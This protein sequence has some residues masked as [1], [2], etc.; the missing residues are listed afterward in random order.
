[1]TRMSRGILVLFVDKSQASLSGNVFQY[2]QDESTDRAVAEHFCVMAENIVL[3]CIRMLAKW[4][5][6]RLP[7]SVRA[8]RQHFALAGVDPLVWR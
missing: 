4:L 8:G 3:F 2:Y 1:M 7:V 5:M 6:Y